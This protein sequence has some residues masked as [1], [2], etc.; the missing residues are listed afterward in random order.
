[1]FHNF[2]L[3]NNLRLFNNLNEIQILPRTAK[4]Y[5][6][7]I[8]SFLTTLLYIHYLLLHKICPQMQVLKELSSYYSILSLRGK[9]L[10]GAQLSRSG[11][12]LTKFQ[13]KCWLVLQSQKTYLGLKD[14]LTAHSHG[15]W[16][17]SLVP[18][19][20]RISTI[21]SQHGFPQSK[22]SK[23]MKDSDQE[24]SYNAFC[25]NLGSNS[26]SILLQDIDHTNQYLCKG[27]AGIIKGT[28]VACFHTL[29]TTFQ[30]RDLPSAPCISQVHSLP[31]ELCI[32]YSFCLEQFS[33]RSWH[34]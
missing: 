32:S 2:K 11:L 15:C 21:Y 16:Q 4:S 14:S 12:S 13:S 8:T 20:M 19:H 3:L 26:P 30:S 29:E 23:R 33:P 18:L 27:G 1:M 22:R 25:N 28:P 31:Q 6:I 10:W 24:G 9:N 34:G 5:M 7:S 17:E